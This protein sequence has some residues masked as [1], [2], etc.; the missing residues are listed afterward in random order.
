MD[1]L[2]GYDSSRP[3][4]YPPRP[5]PHSAPQ[6]PTDR[7]V[8]SSPAWLLTSLSLTLAALGVHY[9]HKLCADSLS[10]DEPPAS[11]DE[12]DNAILTREETPSLAFTPSSRSSSPSSGP[13]FPLNL[14]DNE[15]DLEKADLDPQPWQQ[16]LLVKN[17]GRCDHLPPDM[18]RWDKVERIGR[19]RRHTVVFA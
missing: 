6:S 7:H 16:N 3:D 14:Q 8:P 17:M 19:G 2:P 9:L 13:R 11:E 12:E 4:R 1:A 5:P 10:D 18:A 15:L